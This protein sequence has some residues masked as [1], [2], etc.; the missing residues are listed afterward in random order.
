MKKIIIFFMACAVSFSAGAQQSL[1]TLKMEELRKSPVLSID[2]AIAG[3]IAGV[4]VSFSDD[5]PGRMADYSFRGVESAS[6]LFVV[7]GFRVDQAF[8]HAMNPAQVQS[9]VVLTDIAATSKYGSE[10]CAGVVEITTD[11]GQ[12]GKVKVSADAV[13]GANMLSES[14]LAGTDYVNGAL[15]TA[16]LQNYNVSVSGGSTKAGNKFFANFGYLGDGGVLKGTS[17]NRFQASLSYDQ[18][19][20]RNLKFHLGASYRTDR[21][22]GIATDSPYADY[23][24][25]DE[26]PVPYDQVDSYIMYYVTGHGTDPVQ[27][28]DNAYSRNINSYVTGDLGLDWI[29]ID[30]L[31]LSLR[32]AYSAL[33]T[34]NQSFN[35]KNTLFGAPDSPFGMNVN[36]CALAD[37]CNRYDGDIRLTYA[38]T[39]RNSD[40]IDARVGFYAGGAKDSYRGERSYNMTT[41]VLGAAALSTGTYIP[42]FIYDASYYHLQA[43]ANA[44][45]SI[46]GQVEIFAGLSADS[47]NG[48][49]KGKWNVLPS[50]GAAWNFARTW[51][52]D[53]LTSGRLTAS[54]GENAYTLPVASPEMVS[55]AGQIAK[56]FDASLSAGFWKDRLCA[57][58][59]FYNIN[60]D[61]RKYNGLELS[62]NAYPIKN[63]KLVWS[64]FANTTFDFGPNHLN[65]GGAGT[66]LEVA[67][68]DFRTNV[69]WNPNYFRCANVT[70]GYTLGRNLLKVL[71]MRIFV[72][73]RN[74]CHNSLYSNFDFDYVPATM[75]PG[76]YS[77]TGGISFNF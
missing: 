36:A 76:R 2:E 18:D 25:I 1:D 37:N 21:R 72:N 9:I 7:D 28:L 17:N 14:S 58:L 53:V 77:V 33:N 46:K 73:G 70:A 56:Q 26:T 3:R 47:F 44:M 10:G 31:D 34:D 48:S 57:K 74:I 51:T 45:Y 42:V 68:F 11:R 38:K 15:T 43:Y 61:D 69:Y 71:S 24:I 50:V 41:E 30:G 22:N 8:V 59:G 67:G 60:V 5:A 4:N 49:E 23:M 6:P 16:L 64:I 54:W 65:W 39:F 66:V 32:G 29:I 27:T 20:T 12:Q 62:L 63:D 19:L 40:A 13:L 55:F 52:S 35:N 75:Y